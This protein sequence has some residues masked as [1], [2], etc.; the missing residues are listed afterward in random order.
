MYLSKWFVNLFLISITL[1]SQ[2]TDLK[3]KKDIQTEIRQA[4]EAASAHIVEHASFMRFVDGE[5]RLIKTGT[6]GFTCLVVREPLGRY[7]PTCFNP[8]A[9]QSVFYTYQMH[10]KYLYMG[11]DY[12]QTYQKLVQAFEDEKLPLPEPASLVYMMSPKNQNY[13]PQTKTIKKGMPHQ[14]YFYPKLTD[15]TFSL[16]SGGPFLWQG[17]P[18]MSALIVPVH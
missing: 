17:F 11:Y 3:V 8:P 10:M 18:A 6:N 1:P 4:S 2:A 7:E 5:F 16:A 14:M 13:Y 9:M 12:P 15:E